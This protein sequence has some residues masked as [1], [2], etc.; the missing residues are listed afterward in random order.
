MSY[1]GLAQQS[2]GRALGLAYLTDIV[3]GV[4]SVVAGTDI[5]VNNADPKNPVI[6]YIGGTGGGIATL[7]AGTNITL[8][9]TGADPIV[10]LANNV[11][12]VAGGYFAVAPA[13]LPVVLPITDCLRFY[14]DPAKTLFSALLTCPI[15]PS[16]GGDSVVLVNESKDYDALAVGNI[17]VFKQGDKY[18][19]DNAFLHLGAVGGLGNFG[20]SYADPTI[21]AE[22]LFMD[23]NVGPPTTFNLYNIENANGATYF[24][25]QYISASSITTQLQTAPSGTGLIYDAVDSAS[26]DPTTGNP[27]MILDPSN[28]SHIVNKYLRGTFRVI[29]SIQWDTTSGGV[30]RVEI[31]LA[32]NGTPVPRSGYITALRQQG[33]ALTTCENIVDIPANGFVEVYFYS[34]DANM[35]ASYTAPVPPIP[36]DCPSII[37][38]VQRIA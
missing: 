24:I 10:N 8:T 20:I 7:T 4:Q 35:S 11:E 17:K 28:P 37:T 32:V 14:K 29:T 38:I 22:T 27:M 1:Q 33:E 9:G 36:V 25:P 30:N 21:P 13:T 2:T 15:P 3:E 26:L 18:D 6:S 34:T 19:V 5:A 23:T 12:M 16:G 31:W